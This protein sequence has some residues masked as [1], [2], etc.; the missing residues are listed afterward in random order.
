[1]TW[2]VDWFGATR[3]LKRWIIKLLLLRRRHDAII[4][5]ILL[6]PLNYLVVVQLWGAVIRYISSVLDYLIIVQPFEIPTTFRFKDARANFSLVLVDFHAHRQTAACVWGVLVLLSLYHYLGAA[7][8]GLDRIIRV[9]IGVQRSR[10]FIE[11]RPVLLLKRKIRYC[12]ATRGG[13]QGRVILFFGVAISLISF[14]L[15]VCY[16]ELWGYILGLVS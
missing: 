5:F 13:P 14:A 12:F 2:A 11:A 7:M 3:I 15:S 6:V 8:V 9:S 10:W 1:M 16:F 4:A